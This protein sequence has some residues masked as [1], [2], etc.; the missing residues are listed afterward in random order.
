VR[1]TQ[2]LSNPDMGAPRPLP[3]AYL[4]VETA[5]RGPNVSTDRLQYY[6]LVTYSNLVL[7]SNL[8]RVTIKRIGILSVR[9]FLIR[10]NTTEI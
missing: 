7:T 3:L 9:R 2:A 10:L 1:W 4:L 6:K 5:L 8:S